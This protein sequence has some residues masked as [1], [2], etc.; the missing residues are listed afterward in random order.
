MKHFFNHIVL[1]TAMLF[2]FS[3]KKNDFLVA[4]GELE[5]QEYVY[6][7]AINGFEPEPVIKG[8]I[9][10]NFEIRTVYYYLQ[11]TNKP[12]SL[13]QTDMVPIDQRGRTYD[14]EI[15]S[16]AWFGVDLYGVRGIKVIFVQDN[17]IALEKQIGLSYYDPAAPVISDI[18]ETIR[19]SLIEPT[20]I[21][22][23]LSSE[24]GI[25]KVEIFDNRDGGFDV[26]ETINLEGIHE[27]NLSYPYIYNEGAGQMLIKVIDI[28]GLQ[29]EKVIQFIGIP[30]KPVVNFNASTLAAALPDGVPV[31]AGTLKT[32]S[33]L[34]GLK[35]YVVRANGETLVGDADFTLTNQGQDEYDYIFS[36]DQFPY[37]DDVV[38]CK[39]EA[40]DASGS[41]NAN[42]IPVTIL[43]YYHWKNVTMMSQGF[44]SDSESLTSNSCF[45]IGEVNRPVIG[46]C[47]AQSGNYDSKIDF[48]IYTTT[49][50]AYTFYN[51]NNTGSIRGNY[52]CNGGT[53]GW[54]PSTIK[55]VR[56]RALL[57]TSS[58]NGSGIY[59][60]YNAGNI[61]R[62]DDEFFA[63]VNAP[64]ANTAKYDNVS[65]PA[66]NVF[67][68]NDAYLI[69]LKTPEGKNIL[70]HVKEVDLFSTPNQGKSTAVMDI[71]KQR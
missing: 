6:N 69:W 12:D 32:Y 65:A 45:F 56:I 38:A 62:L 24:T 70:V 5:T 29:T 1:L 47:D 21:S 15:K 8:R 33:E 31:V 14:F 42:S 30:F 18:P 67:H 57:Q 59:T 20:V 54:T 61:Q 46:S 4:S 60:K 22:A 9:D 13:L 52:R 10:A 50:P 71:L 64:S 39:I 28:Y 58:S 19:P 27:Y 16:E 44:F 7:V 40:K 23:K 25:R 51:P 2:L 36:Y 48:V 49:A 37:D 11:R 35:V 63:G 55:D 43:P 34:E 41:V 66:S 68:P 53:T 26:L 17:Q 3:C